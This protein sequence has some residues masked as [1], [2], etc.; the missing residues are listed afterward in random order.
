[1]RGVPVRQRG[2]GQ[3]AGRQGDGGRRRTRRRSGGSSTVSKPVRTLKSRRTRLNQPPATTHTPTA[4]T[5]KKC[6]PSTS[7]VAAPAVSIAT[8]IPSHQSAGLS[9]RSCMARQGSGFAFEMGL[10]G[11]CPPAKHGSS[12]APGRRARGRMEH[13]TCRA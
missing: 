7:V 9:G 2:R 3:C 10:A 12:S 11:A 13:F 8:T 1:M 5:Q 4:P 6:G